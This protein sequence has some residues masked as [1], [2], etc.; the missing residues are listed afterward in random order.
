MLVVMMVI[1][2]AKQFGRQQEFIAIVIGMSENIT[3]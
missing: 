3:E 2:L 1:A